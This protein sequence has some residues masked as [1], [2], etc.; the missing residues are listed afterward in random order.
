MTTLFLVRHGQTVWHADNRYAGVTDVALDGAGQEQAKRMGLWAAEIGFDALWC[1]PLRRARATAAPAAATLGLMPRI[2][3]DLREVDFG[4]AEGHTLAELDP[5]VVAA[6]HA[7]PV[8]GAFPGAEDPRTAAARAAGALH[9]IADRHPGERV[10]VVAHNTLM[11]L[12]LCSML[13]IPL[14]SY[15]RVFPRIRN[16]A[17]TELRVEQGSASLLAYNLPLPG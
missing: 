16:C 13:G 7:D 14:S 8:L 6:F 15:R 12:A 5:A 4:M 10:L 11:R 2:E 17:P 3:G 1:S 9:R